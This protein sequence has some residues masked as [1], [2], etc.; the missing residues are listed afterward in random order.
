MDKASC[1]GGCAL[2]VWGFLEQVEVKWMV[3]WGGRGGDSP[4]HQS[5]IVSS[6]KHVQ[7]ST[8]KNMIEAAQNN[9]NPELFGSSSRFHAFICTNVPKCSCAQECEKF[10]GC[11]PWS[12]FN[13]LSR[14]RTQHQDGRLDRSHIPIYS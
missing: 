7:L 9:A 13:R 2:R 1:S 5:G 3:L 10:S 12:R 4:Q 8:I 6:T 11:C 14:D